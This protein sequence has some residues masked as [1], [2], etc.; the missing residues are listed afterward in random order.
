MESDT[1][2]SPQISDTGL[3]IRLAGRQYRNARMSVQGTISLLTRDRPLEKIFAHERSAHPLAPNWVTL[4][5]ILAL[6][7]DGIAVSNEL[8][9]SHY[10]DTRLSKNDAYIECPST[11]TKLEVRLRLPTA[12]PP[13]KDPCPT[14]RQQPVHL[15]QIK[16]RHLAFSS[17]VYH[18]ST[19]GGSRDEFGRV[20]SEYAGTVFKLRTPDGTAGIYS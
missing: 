7:A 20:V 3:E 2:P 16:I 17:D 5:L 1:V 9:L 18:D 14:L 11:C 15:Q 13:Y 4:T 6:D 10:V 8:D 12:H 19:A